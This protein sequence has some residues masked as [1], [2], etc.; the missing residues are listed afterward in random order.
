[1]RKYKNSELAPYSED[2]L[3]RSAHSHQKVHLQYTL[4]EGTFGKYELLYLETNELVSSR[5]VTFYPIYPG[6]GPWNMSEIER[7]VRELSF[8]KPNYATTVSDQLESKGKVSNT[9]NGEETP[10]KTNTYNGEETPQQTSSNNNYIRRIG[11]VNTIDSSKEKEI[12]GVAIPTSNRVNSYNSNELFTNE[13]TLHP[14]LQFETIPDKTGIPNFMVDGKSKKPSSNAR[15]RLYLD[16]NNGKQ[17][18][19]FNLLNAAADLAP[20]KNFEANQNEVALISLIDSHIENS[21]N[22][23]Y[24]DPR[25]PVRTPE[26]DRE[27][28]KLD[29]HEINKWLKADKEVLEGLIDKGVLE[30]VVSKAQCTTK[31]IPIRMIRKLKSPDEDGR[32]R[33]KSRCA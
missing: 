9:Y 20:M 13:K 17:E 26:N 1:M 19:T 32:R 24:E 5:S 30:E 7:R 2:P 22:H 29:T 10:H 4:T 28:S 12:K 25:Q 14:T 27:L 6:A 23:V 11:G 18:K 8:P 16:M 3:K 15:I 33:L 21:D 31:I